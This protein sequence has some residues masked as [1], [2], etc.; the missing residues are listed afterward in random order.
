[1][2]KIG[3][4]SAIF[5]IAFSLIIGGIFYFNSENGSAEESTDDSIL[6]NK[7]YEYTSD[8][9]K[10]FIKERGYDFIEEYGDSDIRLLKKELLVALDATNLED[11]YVYYE[12]YQSEEMAIRGILY[13]QGDY[14]YS[15]IMVDKMAEFEHQLTVKILDS[16]NTELYSFDVK[17]G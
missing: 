1:M 12:I 14:Y 7:F 17:E 13:L 10:F 11:D 2:K 3:L 4:F 8:E 5:I 6:Y 9:I 16:E 15:N